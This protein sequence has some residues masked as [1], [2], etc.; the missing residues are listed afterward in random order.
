MKWDDKVYGRS[1]LK[2][3]HGVLVLEWDRPAGGGNCR[4]Y[5]GRIL[6]ISFNAP[7]VDE[8]KKEAKA[9]LYAALQETL[10]EVRR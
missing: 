10:D 5:F 2:L 1:V 6:D 4:T 7:S 8:A 3:K 9:L